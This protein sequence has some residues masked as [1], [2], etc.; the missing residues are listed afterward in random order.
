MRAA[1][2]HR[3]R[4]QGIANDI[5]LGAM[6]VVP[7]HQFVDEALASR[8]YGPDALPIGHG[9]TISAPYTVARLCVEA[10]NGRTRLSRVLEIGT[11]CGYQAAVLAQFSAQVISIE[12]IAALQSQAAARLRALGVS[13]VRSILGDGRL[14]HPTL[15]GY[16]A[17]VVAAAGL[18]LPPAWLEQLS[19]GGCLIAP[20]GDASQMLVRIERQSAERWHREVL[21]PVKFV[22]LRE[23]VQR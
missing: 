6:A 16:D 10:L 23:G 18:A 12:R 3:L 22:P 17:I 11:G 15:G 14:G 9:Q 5:V 20:E 1:M 8:A 21:D 2:V 19:V 13:R 7:R 4:E